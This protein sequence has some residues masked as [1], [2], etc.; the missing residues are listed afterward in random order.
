MAIQKPSG[1]QVLHFVIRI[2]IV[3]IFQSVT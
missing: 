1:E 3:K 2:L